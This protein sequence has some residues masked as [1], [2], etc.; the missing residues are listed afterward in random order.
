M[1]RFDENKGVEIYVHI[2]FC[3]KKCAYCDFL[4]FPADEDKVHRYIRALQKEIAL[5]G[6]SIDH[7]SITSIYFG[8]G[9]PSYID[10]EYIS[11]LLDTIY[12]YYDVDDDA[13][14]TIEVN[15]KTVDLEK[16]RKYR[17]YG[18]NRLSIGAQS[19]HDE[20]LK[21]LGRIHTHK[22]FTDCYSWALKAGF[23]NINVDL[24]SG[25]PGQ[26]FEMWSDSLKEIIQLGAKHVS[27]YGLIIEEGTS[28]YEIYGEDDR[29]REEGYEPEILPSEQTERILYYM[30]IEYLC[31]AGYTN[32]E[33]SNFAKP[34]YESRH[35]TGYWIGRE[36]LGMG[37]GSSSYLLGRRFSNCDNIEEY[38]AMCEKGRIKHT[39]EQILTIEEKMEEFMFL[40][41]RMTKGVSRSDFKNRFG[42]SI[43]SV[44]GDAL[45]ELRKTGLLMMIEDR[46][47][48]TSEGID[49]SNYAL[50]KFLIND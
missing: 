43:E 34:G 13:E 39:D 45:N 26:N 3:V 9:T 22:D 24:I 29:R 35:N 50:A 14:I 49:V 44:F 23:E 47:F 31:S 18:V 40:G 48:L 17:R 30:S 19:T 16:L 15:P 2:P 25:I 20:I 42:V 21:K 12:Y 28:F 4:S 5:R 27:T 6:S 38:I 1:T 10:G 33:I 7:K 36:Y 41:L 32:Y 11:D 8:G 46:I 37:L